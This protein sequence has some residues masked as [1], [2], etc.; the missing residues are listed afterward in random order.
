MTRLIVLFLLMFTLVLSVSAQ[1]RPAYALYTSDGK[2]A[3]YQQLLEASRATDVVLFGELHN[4]PIAH[5]LQF[6]LAADLATDSTRAMAI[7]FEMFEADQQV[8]LDEYASGLISTANFEREARLWPNYKTDYKPVLELGRSHGIRLVATN[9]PRRYASAVY[10]RGLEALAE[11][12][13]EARAWMM[14]LPVEVDLS[15]PGYANIMQAAGG[16]GG[17]NLPYSQAVK[18]AAMAHFIVH[19]L[20][21]GGRLLHLHGSYHTDNREGIIWYLQRERA[22]IRYVS[23][24]TVE[25]SVSLVPDP[26]AETSR[27]RN[28]RNRNTSAEPVMMEVLPF[29]DDAAGRADFILVV[30]RNMTKTH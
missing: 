7:G 2:P 29:P 20:A 14:P 16:H 24:A 1:H 8:L 28:S 17:V 15:L 27:N 25:G 4:N 9:I 12:S 30:H 22:D 11:L 23:I 10:S 26:A 5:W 3:T 21:P 13:E 19:N 6:E 18:D